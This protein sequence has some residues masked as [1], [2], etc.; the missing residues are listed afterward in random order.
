MT[1]HDRHRCT[2]NVRNPQSPSLLAFLA[3]MRN[4]IVPEED[5]IYDM[6]LRGQIETRRYRVRMHLDAAAYE[7]ELVTALRGKQV[8]S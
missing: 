3:R 8:Q 2:G 1:A 4:G 6:D 7:Q 5:R